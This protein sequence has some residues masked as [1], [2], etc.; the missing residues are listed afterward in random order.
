MKKLRLILLVFSFLLLS[1]PVL[2]LTGSIG[3]PKI[4]ISAETGENI[5]KTLLVENKNNVFVDIRLTASGDI[6][7]DISLSE[8]DFRLSPAE[9]KEV[10]F[11]VRINKP[12]RHE[13]KILVFF[14]HEDDVGVTL[15]SEIIVNVE[16]E[17]VD[18]PL[19]IKI[20]GSSSPITSSSTSR[21]SSGTAQS[22]DVIL[23]VILIG[24]FIIIILSVLLF[25]FILTG[26]RKITKEPLLFKLVK[27][28]LRTLGRKIGL[29]PQ[30]EKNKSSKKRGKKKWNELVY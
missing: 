30:P 1:Q 23:P 29:I 16:G 19:K 9:N 13:G 27:K 24:I 10:P 8:T 7:E 22:N 11:T 28:I 26:K 12:G 25:S 15:T 21:Q 5:E 2:A 17:Q 3:S 4:V 18:E 14:S 6:S 20:G